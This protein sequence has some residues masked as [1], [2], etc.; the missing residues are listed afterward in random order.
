[1]SENIEYITLKRKPC[2]FC[3]PDKRDETIRTLA[4]E[5]KAWRKYHDSILDG[6]STQERHD[7]FE[8]AR[9]ATDA[10]KLKEME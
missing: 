3:G 1:M 8:A 4:A 10:L 2:P 6:T 9:A 7:A 5:V